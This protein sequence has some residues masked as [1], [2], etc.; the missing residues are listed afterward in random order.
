MTKTVL[1]VG[2][3]VPPGAQYSE[4]ISEFELRGLFHTAQHF[5]FWPNFLVEVSASPDNLIFTELP[6]MDKPQPWL[7]LPLA[8]IPLDSLA[9]MKT[10]LRALYGHF[11]GDMRKYKVSHKNGKP[12]LHCSWPPAP[13]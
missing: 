10:T 6:A 13:G 11:G 12:G 4:Y 2:L 5:K 9:S 7:D 8:S 3:Y 1:G